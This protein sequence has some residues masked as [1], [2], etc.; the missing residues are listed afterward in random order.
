MHMPRL[1]QRRKAAI[2]GNGHLCAV[3]TD[4]LNRLSH[5]AFVPVVRTLKDELFYLFT[6]ILKLKYNY[7]PRF[8]YSR[9][10]S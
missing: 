2:A 7:V 5:R 8:L 9:S 6:E 4:F 3:L 10:E 1:L